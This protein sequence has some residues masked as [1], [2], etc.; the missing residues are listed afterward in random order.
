METN[1]KVRPL[2]FNGAGIIAGLIIGAVIGISVLFITGSAGLIGAISA[3]VAIPAGIFLE[4][5]IRE[6]Q[7][8]QK[9]KAE[10]VYM[11]LIFLGSVMFFMCCF[12]V[13]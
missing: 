11:L 10:I 5:R 13:K 2:V 8:S 1:E 4:N 12:L 6:K 3:A 7:S 9:R